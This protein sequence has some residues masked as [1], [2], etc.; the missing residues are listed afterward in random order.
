MK[1]FMLLDQMVD[2][3]CLFLFF[4]S[5]SW[6]PQ[7]CVQRSVCMAVVFPQTPATVSLAGEDLTAPVVSLGSLGLGQPP[8]SGEPV[9]GTC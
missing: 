8:G 9:L 5:L 4:L 3:H 6:P 7:P 2:F 1:W